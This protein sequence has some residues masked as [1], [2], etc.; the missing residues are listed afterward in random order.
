MLF[1]D[2]TFEE[3][4]KFYE[5]NIC[6][7]P[8]ELTIEDI[9]DSNPEQVISGLKELQHLF[10]EVYT[11]KEIFQEEESL[12]SLHNVMNT[13]LFL[14]SAGFVGELLKD[15]EKWYLKVD[16]KLMKKHYKKPLNY[17]MEKLQQFGLYYEYYKNGNCVEALNRCAEFVLRCEQWDNALLALNYILKKTQL[18][19]TVKDYARMQ[20]LFYKLDYRSLLLKESTKRN[21]IN[22]FRKDIIKTAGENSVFLESLLTKLL[23]EYPLITKIKIHEYHSPHWVLQ[24]Y[25]TNTDKFIFILNVAADTICL[26]I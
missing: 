19:L 16:K 12:K 9:E 18:N 14:Y 23:G 1:H 24:F 25:N 13:L 10:A 15:G 6:D 5:V 22:A 7:F 3:R 8:M 4:I 21:Q 17:P 26:E 20:G 11:S 2:Q